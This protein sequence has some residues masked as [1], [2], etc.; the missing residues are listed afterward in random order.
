V[1]SAKMIEKL[2]S[3]L[4]HGLVEKIIVYGKHNF[5]IIFKFNMDKLT[6]GANNE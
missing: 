5:E 2:P 6:G 4:I 1:F 3:D